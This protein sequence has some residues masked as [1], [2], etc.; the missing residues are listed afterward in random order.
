[1]S[2]V[3]ASRLSCTIYTITV[4]IALKNPFIVDYLMFVVCMVTTDIDP[5]LMVIQVFDPNSLVTLYM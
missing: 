4:F 2:G 1:M 5:N 3:A